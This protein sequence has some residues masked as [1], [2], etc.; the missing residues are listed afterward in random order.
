MLP[1]YK[2]TIAATTASILSKLDNLPDK[3]LKKAWLAK[4]C[5]SLG[6]PLIAAVE[7][8]PFLYAEIPETFLGKNGELSN[9]EQAIILSLQ[10]YA[11]HQQ[12]MDT[13]VL[14]TGEDKY[15]NFG[16]ALR[17]L[18]QQQQKANGNSSA[19][20]TRFNALITAETFDELAYH[21]RH[22]VK[23]L[24]AKDSGIKINYAGLA[25]DLFYFLHGYRRN[26]FL[27]WAKTYYYQVNKEEKKE[28]AND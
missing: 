7:V 10:L 28:P 21:L 25:Q 16:A 23:L 6:K 4:L 27:S 1:Q 2:P 24:K 5:H 17:I 9:A 3:S 12:G 26:I 11:Q 13:S 22:L 8:F 18:R 15:H 20:D 19:L 14:A